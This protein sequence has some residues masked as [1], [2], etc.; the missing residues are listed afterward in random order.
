MNSTQPIS[1]KVFKYENARL[2][3]PGLRDFVHAQRQNSDCE[4]DG[5]IDKLEF[6]GQNMLHWSKE[7]C[8]KT[9]KEIEC[10]CRKIERVRQHVGGGNINYFTSLKR[11][12][13]IFLVK[14]DILWKQ[15][16]KVH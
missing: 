2:T 1:R 15:I 4:H 6:Y 16:A 8:N 7:N 11:R 3:E 10:I 5:I 13:N 9:R 12:M 14:D